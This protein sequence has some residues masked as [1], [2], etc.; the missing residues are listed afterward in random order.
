MPAEVYFKLYMRLCYSELLEK[1]LN[2]PYNSLELPRK[3]CQCKS[4]Y[5]VWAALTVGMNFSMPPQ[6][7]L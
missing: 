5:E 3:L 1:D 2:D 7:Q 4:S 6:T